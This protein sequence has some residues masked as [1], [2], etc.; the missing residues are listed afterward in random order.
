MRNG[1]TRRDWLKIAAATGAALALGTSCR[2]RKGQAWT[3]RR[4]IFPQGVASGDPAEDSVILWTRRPPAGDSIA[5]QLEVEVAL[6]RNFEKIVATGLAM[7][8]EQTDW[9][10]RFLAASLQPRTEYWYRFKDEFGY[11]SRIGRTVTAPGA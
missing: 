4:D 9:T 10:C 8:D 3:E 1:I 7:V 6:D 11:G 5:R 2:S